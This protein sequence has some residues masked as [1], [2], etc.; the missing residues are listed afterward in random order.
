MQKFARYAATALCALLAADPVLAQRGTDWM[1]NGY[2]PQRSSWVRSDGKISPETMR[3]P[4]FELLWKL[5]LDDSPRQL[6]TLTPPALLDFYI[7]YR[8]FRTL[9]FFGVSSDRVVAVDVDL[10]RLEW[11]TKYGGAAAAGTQPSPGRL[12]SAVT[13][14]TTTYYPPFFQ[15]RG[16]GRATPAK[17]GVGAPDAGAVT[18]KPDSGV[19]RQ[20]AAKKKAAATTPDAYAARIQ[21]VLALS[22]DGKLHSLWVSNGNEPDPPLQFVPPGANA[23]G[24]VAWGNTAYVATTNGCGG[25]DNGVWSLDLKSRNVNRWKSGGPVAGTFG[26]AVRPDGT[27]FAAAGSE[28]AALS[29]GTLKPV[30]TYKANGMEFTSSP[31]MFEFKGKDLIAVAANDGRLLLFDAGA[32]GKGPLD[33]TEPSANP[34]YAVGSLTSW[35]DPAGV[36]WVLA[37]TSNALAA[38]KVVDKNGAMGWERGWTSTEMVSPLPP[39]VIDGVLFALSSGEFHSPDAKLS[40]AERA[41]KSKPAVLYALDPLSG[42]EMWTSGT[43][44]ASFVH[45]GGLSAGGGRIYVATYDG[46]EYAFGFPMEH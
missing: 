5:K 2:D 14:P 22:G 9:A 21:Y 35:Q 43:T 8:G 4:G 15:A 11:E 26:F 45:S 16:A 46:V 17:S 27:L 36:R 19:R 10:G 18:I 12:T 20:P 7:G 24:L 6:N 32:L 42:K 3:K 33:K 13:R 44:I 41:R 34:H 23:E 39:V 30:A 31:V 28:L 37:P 1:T 38:W 29:Q 25:V 40:A